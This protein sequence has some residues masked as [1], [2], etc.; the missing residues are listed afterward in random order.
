MLIMNKLQQLICVLLEHR[1]E[2]TGYQI[3][4]FLKSRTKH[5]HQQIYREC[6]K[7]EVN[8][9]V[10]FVDVINNDR[11]D[12]KV[13]KIVDSGNTGIKHGYSDFSKTTG[14]MWCAQDDAKLDVDLHKQYVDH[15][16]RA[17]IEFF[18]GML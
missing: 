11:P 13:Y 1:G 3:A 5:S 18:E 2:M 17:E 16:K 6:K 15:M 10:S 8:G 14:A 4:K 9:L 7:L 12:A